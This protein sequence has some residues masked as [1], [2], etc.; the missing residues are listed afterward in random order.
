M[1]KRKETVKQPEETMEELVAS[2]ISSLTSG[3]TKTTENIDL[4]TKKVTSMACHIIALEALLSEVI[5]ITGVDLARVNQK[6]RSTI[7]ADPTARGDSEI[8]IDIAASIASQ[9]RC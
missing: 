6:I 7:A 8:V 1:A 5:A 2:S 9:K 3:M 4:L